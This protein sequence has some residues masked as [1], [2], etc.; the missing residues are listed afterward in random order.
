MRP[1][2]TQSYLLIKA[3]KGFQWRGEPAEGL[4]L[5]SERDGSVCEPLVSYFGAS[6]R[7]NRVETSSMYQEALILREWWA[8]LDAMERPW[9]DVSDQ[10]LVD[11]R[12][13]LKK[14]ADAEVVGTDRLEVDA[15]N[16]TVRKLEVVFGFYLLAG[17]NAYGV[18]RRTF[19]GPRG[20]LTSAEKRD[21]SGDLVW[22]LA[23]PRRTK[24]GQRPT[25]D[26]L[27]VS[28]ILTHLRSQRMEAAGEILEQR[29]RGRPP[30]PAVSERDWLIG[31]AMVEGG[32]RA[33]ECARLDVKAIARGL[34]EAGINLPRPDEL[35]QSPAA[36]SL[37]HLHPLDAVAFSETARVHV[38][39]QIEMQRRR[40]RRSI[41][42]M[43]HG[44]GR[45]TRKV[46][47]PIEYVTD[48][49]RIG[50]WDIR[51]REIEAGTEKRKG[52]RPDSAAFLPAGGGAI[53]GLTSGHIGD[54]MKGAFEATGVPGSGHRLRAWYATKTCA[55][56]FEEAFALNGNRW[57]QTVENL[58]LEQLAQALGHVKVTTAVRSYLDMQLMRY[59]DLKDKSKLSLMRRATQAI[60]Q[61]SRDLS[62][63]DF[64]RIIA[65]AG[66]LA[67]GPPLFRDV[68]DTLMSDPDLQ[69]IAETAASSR[70]ARSSFANDRPSLRIVPDT[71]TT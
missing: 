36:V 48:L 15:H 63:P 16:R 3:P 11:W 8:Y 69:P 7:F 41:F 13:S 46:P 71:S 40:Y 26:E 12:T 18:S 56:L 68:F 70:S 28:R 64:D 45:K 21:G 20:P 4:P 25:P 2:A 35:S 29:K 23:K 52:A 47:L 19:V 33:D 65:F 55:R 43:V 39:D 31:V 49:L 17:Q 67:N 37:S 60:S 9:D 61:H 14:K 10:L 66:R 34:K 59:F 30:N 51:R 38:L 24:I 54:L 5:M 6:L 58:V 53:K 22:A 42:V 62:K 32:L 44:K 50:V 1:S 27:A 57:D